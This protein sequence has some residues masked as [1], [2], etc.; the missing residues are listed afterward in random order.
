M[1]VQLVGRTPQDMAAGAIY[2]ASRGGDYVV[3]SALVIDGGVVNAS[4]PRDFV[5]DRCGI[6]LLDDYRDCPVSFG[7]VATDARFGEQP[8]IGRSTPTGQVIKM[9]ALDKSFRRV[10][11]VEHHKLRLP[12]RH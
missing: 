11:D 1:V 5:D 10:Q 12:I 2:L 7:E 8:P 3:G 9:T 4:L 6:T